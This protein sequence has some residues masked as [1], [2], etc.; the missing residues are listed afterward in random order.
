MAEALD[1]H[2]LLVEGSA[3]T[4]AMP[5]A[6]PDVAPAVA[7]PA[8]QLLDVPQANYPSLPLSTAFV[9][10]VDLCGQV[11]QG[12]IYLC[13]GAPGSNKSTLARQLALDLARHGHR[14]LFV[15]TEEPPARLKAA[16]LRMTA[17]WPPQ[18]VRSALAN[19]QVEPSVG[20][21]QALPD[22]FARQ[23][24]SPDGSYA[25]IRLIV[26]DSIQGSGLS[27]AATA[28]WHGLY[29]FTALAR[30]AGVTALLICHVTKKNEI[31]G[32]RALEH[33]ID[34][35]W[36]LRKAM[37]YRP[38]FVPKNRF[39]PEACRPLPLEVD[40]VRVCLTVSPHASALTS[41]ARSYLPGLGTT[42]VQGAVTLPRWGTA[43][44]IMAP[45]LPRREIEQLVS[46]I[47]QIP[48]LEL[49]DLNHSIQCRLPGERSYRGVLGLPLCM[50]LVSSYLQRPIPPRQY[51]LGEID[52]CRQVRDLPP[53]LVN[54]LAAAIN[55]GDVAAPLRI[56][57]PPSAARA[58]PR[59][60]GVEV[61]P[62]ATLDEAIFRTWPDLR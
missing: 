43:A 2:D 50:A 33:N 42:E 13:A 6:D 38:L 12:G 46:C 1:P 23:V 11:V 60:P 47:G 58:L 34:C 3:G 59:G 61:L 51:Q 31:A 40:P 25:G 39:G 19:L 37:N 24:M 57:C 21:V 18:D 22:F 5:A 28:K 44:R 10:L 62:C 45:G 48:G 30:A 26:V 55:R 41:V 9:W 4:G 14:T 52:L 36:V 20:D 8:N 27:T 35:A 7:G 56:I 15:L 16:L 29:R 17:D 53:A 49:D 54:D 32:P